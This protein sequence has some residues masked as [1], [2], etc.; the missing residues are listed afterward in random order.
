MSI[1]LEN[2]GLANRSL[3]FDQSSFVKVDWTCVDSRQKKIKGQLKSQRLL[4][5]KK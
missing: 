2:T 3:I 4:K 1:Q 5:S